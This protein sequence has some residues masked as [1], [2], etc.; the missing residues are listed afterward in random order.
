[1]LSEKRAAAREGCA[2]PWER[3]LGARPRGDGSAEF[4]VWAPRAS[5]ISL[6]VAEAEFELEDAG[7][8]VYETVAPASPGTDYWF[9]LDGHRL[10]DPGSR[11]QPAGLRGPSRVG[12]F[13]AGERFDGPP[14]NQL[15]IYELHVGTF[16]AE[17]T[18]AGAIPHLRE[19]AE[20]GVSAIEIM[21]VA[22]FPGQRGWGYDGVY[23]SAPQSSYGGPAGLAKLVQVAHPEGLAVLL[24]VVYNHVGTSGV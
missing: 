22:E 14:L 19:L 10:P 8:G 13:P 18:F 17:G 23:L 1:M 3:A 16:S 2:Y 5:S 24:D 4:R 7:Y 11:W 15:V 12:P 21:P 20:L 9:V 6:I